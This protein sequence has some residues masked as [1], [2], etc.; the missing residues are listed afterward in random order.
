M[1]ILDE[2][3]EKV[4]M[5]EVLEMYGRR[6]VRGR[7][8]YL[9][10]AHEDKHPSAGLTKDGT[11]F[12]CFACNYTGNIFD[13]VQ[14]F[15]QCDLKT[16]IKILDDKFSLGLCRE[17]SSREKREI[18][19][20]SEEREREKREKLWW[21]QY[22][23]LVLADIIKNLRLN[24][25]AERMLRIQKGQYRGAWS[26]EY[27]D[28]YFYVLK[29]LRWLE[30]LYSAISGTLHEESEY[31]YIYPADKKELLEMIKS[32]AISI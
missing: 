32:G 10:F 31:D 4:S 18:A 26:N 30:W 20:K 9:C 13:V 28:V 27:G 3:K 8:N 16:A 25:D 11:K 5:L 15:E 29:Q 17:L 6:P 14:H 21:E 24:E 1:S 2:I 7:N 22:E 12:H 19:R 23:Q